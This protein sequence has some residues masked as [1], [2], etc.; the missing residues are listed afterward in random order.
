[1][2]SIS[3]GAGGDIASLGGTSV[4]ATPDPLDE[5]ATHIW[6]GRLGDGGE[7]VHACAPVLDAAGSDIGSVSLG[8]P[9]A[10]ALASD[11]LPQRKVQSASTV[12][13]EPPRLWEVTLTTLEP[14]VTTLCGAP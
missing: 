9:S 1:M 5:L 3:V 2:T 7:P 13:T 8:A 11:D 6:L 4:T 14:Q 10:L 12:I